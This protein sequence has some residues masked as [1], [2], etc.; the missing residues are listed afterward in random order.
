MAK[1]LH[2]NIMCSVSNVSQRKKEKVDIQNLSSVCSLWTD[3]GQSGSPCQRTSPHGWGRGTPLPRRWPNSPGW[4]GALPQGSLCHRRCSVRSSWR[5]DKQVN[6]YPHVR[7]V[8]VVLKHN[9]NIFKY[10]SFPQ[11]LIGNIYR[12]GCTNPSDVWGSK[13]YGS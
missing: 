9:Y 7:L 2:G 4:G 3:G 11:L 5:E 12:S 8:Y 10:S 1:V 13:T 6:K